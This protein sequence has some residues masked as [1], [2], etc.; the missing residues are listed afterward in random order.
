MK[1]ACLLNQRFLRSF[2]IIYSSVWKIKHFC[3]H[4]DLKSIFMWSYAPQ[5]KIITLC[6]MQKESNEL[7]GLKPKTLPS[8]HQ[9]TKYPNHSFT[10]IY[11]GNVNTNKLTPGKREKCGTVGWCFDGVKTVIHSQIAQ[12]TGGYYRN[13]KYFVPL[14]PKKSSEIIEQCKTLEPTE[15]LS[16]KYFQFRANQTSCNKIIKS[17]VSILFWNIAQHL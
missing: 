10:I 12:V 2:W 11:K 8:P 15:K 13:C 1:D 5:I 16:V 17:T 7:M 14:G 9:P 6:F 3:V 4:E